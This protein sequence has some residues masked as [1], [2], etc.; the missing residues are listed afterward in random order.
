M[1]IR[2]TRCV[3]K[4][5]SSY[6]KLINNIDDWS[7]SWSKALASYHLFIPPLVLL[8]RVNNRRRAYKS[9]IITWVIGCSRIDIKPWR[10]AGPRWCSLSRGCFGSR[11]VWTLLRRW[12][13]ANTDTYDATRGGQLHVSNKQQGAARPQHGYTQTLSTLIRPLESVERSH[14]AEILLLTSWSWCLR[15]LAASCWQ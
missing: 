2:F 13:A 3:Q 9:I 8:Y 12:Q 11:S 6:R 4:L 15:L 7:H 5:L 14:C 1:S 10:S